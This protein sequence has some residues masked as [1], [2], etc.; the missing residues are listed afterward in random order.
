MSN[1][2]M[3][4]TLLYYIYKGRSYL[5]NL[6]ARNYMHEHE[7]RKSAEEAP[8]SKQIFPFSGTKV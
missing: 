3:A 4:Y 1:Q 7:E 6:V 8:I 2:E 5:Q